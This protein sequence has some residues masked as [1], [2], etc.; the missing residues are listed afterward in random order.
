[1]KRS[2]RSRRR[3]AEE[4]K[5][6]DY[7]LNLKKSKSPRKDKKTVG[8]ERLLSSKSSREE[9]SGKLLIRVSIKVKRCIIITC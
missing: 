4:G 3:W 2:C 7:A 8:L 6:K 1:M 9:R 5:A